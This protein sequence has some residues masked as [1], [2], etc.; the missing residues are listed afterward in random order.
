[1]KLFQKKTAPEMTQEQLRDV[2]AYI[3]YKI[4]QTTP[5]EQRSGEQKIQLRG[6]LGALYAKLSVGLDENGQALLNEYMKHYEE[7]IR[8]EKDASFIE[9]RM[10]TLFVL[11][12]NGKL[13][14]NWRK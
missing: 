13:K 5:E 4:S 9:G 2:E 8:L 11:D 1:M 14:Q 10:I 3:Q 12:A 6:D 7:L